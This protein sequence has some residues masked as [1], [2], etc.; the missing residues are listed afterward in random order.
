MEKE[1]IQKYLTFEFPTQP[2]E[3]LMILAVSYEK[4]H[5]FKYPP[6]PVNVS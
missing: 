1:M 3:K 2:V 6:S 4:E 5:N